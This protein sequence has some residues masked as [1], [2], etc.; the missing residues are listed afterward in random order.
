[1]SD[2]PNAVGNNAQFRQQLESHKELLEA[3]TLHELLGL[4]L[5][6][7]RAITRFSVILLGVAAV[8][9]LLALWQYE[10]L[11]AVVGYGG[12]IGAFALLTLS[13]FVG[14]VCGDFGQRIEMMLLALAPVAAVSERLA[15]KY[16]PRTRALAEMGERLGTAIEPGVL[17]PDPGLIEAALTYPDTFVTRWAFG[18]APHGEEGSQ[19]ANVLANI[20]YQSVAQKAQL[21]CLALLFALVSAALLYRH[22]Y[23]LIDAD[24]RVEACFAAHAVHAPT[25]RELGHAG[26]LSYCLKSHDATDKWKCVS[27]KLTTRL[28]LAA[29][30]KECKILDEPRREPTKP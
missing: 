15:T 21:V 28:P 30:R 6:R 23:Q 29:A 18:V 17:T 2:R 11:V 24:Q 10:T 14:L 19:Y 20:A 7:S 27:Q 9:A 5:A 26:I 16:A 13:A 8:A 22:G 4:H 1:M 12:A 3:E 25:V